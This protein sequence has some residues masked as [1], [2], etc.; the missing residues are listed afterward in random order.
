MNAHSAPS[1]GQPPFL[2]DRAISAMR[3]L[4]SQVPHRPIQQ[5]QLLALQIASW[6]HL[7]QVGKIEEP[8]LQF[9]RT[10]VHMNAIP[11]ILEGLAKSLLHEADRQ[12]FKAR[13]IGLYEDRELFSVL[14]C[15]EDLI[16]CNMFSRIYSAEHLSALA[17]FSAT[18][19]VTSLR[20]PSELSQLLV[21]LAAPAAG[22]EMLICYDDTLS[23]GL[24]AA[25][26]AE[27]AHIHVETPDP[28]LPWVFKLASASNF[29]IASHDPLLDVSPDDGDLAHF[30]CGIISA[31]MGKRYPTESMHRRYQVPSTDSSI[32]GIQHALSK[33]S[34]RTV[35]LVPN[36]LLFASGDA[37]NLR[38][39]L[40]R[41]KLLFA[42][43]SLPT[44]LLQSTSVEF[45]ILILQH[46][47]E[48]V[49]FIEG[50]TEE[51]FN[52]DGRGRST[53]NGWPLLVEIFRDPSAWPT[54]ASAVAH[55]ALEASGQAL[56]PRRHIGAKR[57]PPTR[58]R[59][60]RELGELV[61]IHRPRPRV[62]SE[63]TTPVFEVG[64][65]DFPKFGK[66]TESSRRVDA[67]TADLSKALIQPN[68]IL[69]AAKG[70]I[71][72]V[73]MAGRI[74]APLPMVVSQACVILRPHPR[75]RLPPEI[76]FAYLRSNLGQDLLLQRRTG[77]TV[78]NLLAKDI[79]SLPVEIPSDAECDDIRNLLERQ[80]I[81]QFQ[82][83]VLLREQA[84][85]GD[86]I[87][88]IFEGGQ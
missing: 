25:A 51:F 18:L 21:T 2:I 42:V 45:S 28:T 65:S 29:S 35:A 79:S 57:T 39:Y 74:C 44:A 5:T 13:H 75:S 3:E 73:A 63:E 77:N 50:S 26:V 40:L 11:S 4:A 59:Q 19:E 52:R 83:D 38:S 31:P 34:G 41:Q 56:L 58:G 48:S 64:P 84:M 20:L 9:N 61:S 85:N 16:R 49:V 60:V 36:N 55:D 69:L 87:C 54:H 8:N 72:K 81:L 88:Q 7:S 53:L 86:L 43:I 47:S 1:S 22:T 71:G 17:T 37:N 76:L 66:L 68:D 80:E 78:P 15:A 23:K 10:D 12:I 24:I 70:A 6:M 46:N 30:H 82:V 14:E 32:L 27:Q 33:I 62:A 67:P